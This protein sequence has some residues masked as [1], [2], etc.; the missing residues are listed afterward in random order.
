MFRNFR[1]VFA[2]ENVT[3]AVFLLDLSCNVRNWDFVL[4]ELYP[5]DDVVDW[6]FFN[7]FQSHPQAGKDGNC[8]RMAE[9]LYAVLGDGVIGGTGKA[10]PWGVGAWGTMNQTFGDP[11][12]GYPAKPI[13]AA[14]RQLCIE[15]MMAVLEG[16]DFSRLKAAVYFNSLNSM[17]SPYANSSYGSPELAPTLQKML[18]LDVFTAND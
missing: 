2:E 17:I 14:D 8:S 9:E 4:K 16:A 3:N 11:A 12:H 6:A 10:V 13:A 1:H 5:G 7:L 15:Q 18:A